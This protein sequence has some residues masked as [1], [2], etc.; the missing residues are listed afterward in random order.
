MNNIMQAPT[1][2]AKEEIEQLTLIAA[3][4]DNSKKWE[5]DLSYALRLGNEFKSKTAISFNTSDGE[6]TVETTVWSL[7]D[8]YVQLKGAVL[9]PLHSITNVHY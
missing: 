5:K 8:K 3:P 1:V 9:I 2:I 6:R 7:T 4:I